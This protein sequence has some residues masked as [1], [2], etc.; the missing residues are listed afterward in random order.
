M[1]E[2]RK[3]WKEENKDGLKKAFSGLSEDD[4]AALKTIRTDH[5]AAV[6][7]LKDTYSKDMSMEE[8]EAMMA[9]M[10][11]LHSASDV[12]TRELLEGNEAALEM[13]DKRDALKAKNQELREQNKEVRKEYRGKRSDAIEGQKTRFFAKIEAVLPK[14][15]DAKLEKINIRIA[16]SIEKIEANESM[17][18]ERKAKYLDQLIGLKEI[19]EDAMESREVETEDTEIDDIIS[20]ALN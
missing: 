10:K 4:K 9:E 13:L 1:K 3:T 19:I 16:S 12:K 18:A 8:K 17:D 7:M 15:S 11:A 2:N 20:E 5:R 6:G 14:I